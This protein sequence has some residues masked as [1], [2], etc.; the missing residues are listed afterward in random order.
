MSQP[1][2]ITLRHLQQFG[3]DVI[4]AKKHKLSGKIFTMNN[5][6]HLLGIG[7]LSKFY[8]RTA[9]FR[10]PNRNK[11]LLFGIGISDEETSDYSLSDLGLFVCEHYTLLLDQTAVELGS[12]KRMALLISLAFHYVQQSLVVFE[13]EVRALVRTPL[14]RLTNHGRDS[15]SPEAFDKV[16]AI[17]KCLKSE[18]L[19]KPMGRKANA[20]VVA[21][22]SLLM[23]IQIS[24]IA[25]QSK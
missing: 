9:R 12:K 2:G 21:Q 4:T 13:D 18:T 8:L 25:Y 19:G 22:Y 1:Q 10:V 14:L 15:Q 7:I 24:P 5:V 6:S 3:R 20:P 11:T 23:T 16:T 17:T